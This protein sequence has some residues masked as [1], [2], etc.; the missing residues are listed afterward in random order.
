MGDYGAEEKMMKYAVGIDLG[1]TKI[2]TAVADR[3]RNIL[4]RVRLPTSADK[5]R[6]A[7]WQNIFL[8]LERAARKANISLSTIKRIGIGVPGPVDYTRGIVRICPNIP[9]WENI[10]VKQILE[11]KYQAEVILEN[12]ARAAGLAEA[13]LGAGR[14]FGHI[15]YVTLSTGIGGAIIIDGEI[16][17]GADGA[18]GEVGHTRFS[19]G[20]S[21]EN[22]ASG[23]AIQRIFDIDPRGLKKNLSM[24]YPEARQVLDH[25][26]HYLGICLGNIATLLNPGVIIIGGGLANLGNILL[27]PLEKEVRRNAFSI[28]GQNVKLK[29]AELKEDSGVLGALELCSNYSSGEKNESED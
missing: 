25:L 6:D 9:G 10:P 19:G 16:Y 4:S 3:K 22:L 11:E 23:P 29:K 24:G 15:F 8:S 13:R 17:H 21:L 20:A 14:G 12:D 28:S 27:T 5:G 18:A 1:G 26:V 7:V 2:H